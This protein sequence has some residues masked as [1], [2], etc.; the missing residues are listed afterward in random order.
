MEDKRD[1]RRRE[2]TAGWTDVAM[3]KQMRC[4]DG[5]GTHE[6]DKLLSQ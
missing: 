6:L 5:A 2:E 3:A 1:G 4:V